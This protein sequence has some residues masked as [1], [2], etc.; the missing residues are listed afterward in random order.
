MLQLLKGQSKNAQ[1]LLLIL[2]EAESVKIRAQIQPIILMMPGT[3]SWLIEL[4]LIR[5]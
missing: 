5:N 4:M 2:E 1:V 3:G